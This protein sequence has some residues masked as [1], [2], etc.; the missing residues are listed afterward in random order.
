MNIY[1]Q[2]S[3]LFLCMLLLTGCA[4][5]DNT[6]NNEVPEAQQADSEDS[7]QL[8]DNVDNINDHID[9]SNSTLSK[10][11]FAGGCFWGVEAFFKKVYGVH[12]VVSG[13]ANGTGENPSYQDVIKGDEGFV[14]AVEV[15]FDPKRIDLE[16]LVDDLFL[17][18]DPTSKNKQGNDVGIQY[19]TGVYSKDNDDLD[20]IEKAVDDQQSHYDKK[21]KTEVEPLDNFYLAEDVHQDYL[22]KNPNGYCHID[23][24]VTDDL[25]IHPIDEDIEIIKKYSVTDSSDR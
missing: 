9:Y 15:T 21:I 17:V 24:R 16:T 23:L 6:A 13:Y 14:E 1:R 10:V 7:Y 25:A 22:E 11:Y 12:D 3:C 8:Q 19:R 4:H 18:I 20:L 5:S 2:I